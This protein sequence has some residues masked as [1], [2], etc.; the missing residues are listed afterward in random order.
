MRNIFD[1]YSQPENRITHALVTALNEDR[2][3]LNKF[4]HFILGSNKLN[5]KKLHVLEQSLPETP[6]PISEKDSMGLPDAWI[7]DNGGWCLLIESKVT[8][9]LKLSQLNRHVKTARKR[10]F[11]DIILLAIDSKPN[12]IKLPDKFI[13][14]EWSEIYVW[15]KGCIAFSEWALR[16]ASYFEIAEQK[17]ISDKK[18]Q[19]GALTVFSG[20]PFNSEN[21]YSY[22]EAKR[23]LVLAMEKLRN[24]KKLIKVLNIDSDREGRG[25]ITGKDQPAV[26][27]YIW[28]KNIPDDAN[29]TNYPHL[30]MAIKRD[31]VFAL[32]AIPNGIKKAF[33]KELLGGSQENF[34]SVFQA[35]FENF[36]NTSLLDSG[37]IP[38]VEILQR[39]YQTQR[40]APITDAKLEFDMRTFFNRGVKNSPVKIQK[41]WLNSVFETLNHKRANTQ[42]GVGAIFP[43]DKCKVAQGPELID[44]IAESWIACRPIIKKTIG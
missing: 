5:P 32:I 1:Q 3:L 13:F 28:F 36:I 6:E 42:L 9:P 30:T 8:A 16:T 19:E 22:S 37:V 33:L 26:W 17:M 18:F 21:P 4:L 29:F 2:K 25:A 14:K 24:H 20:I 27:D 12:K 31:H 11:E 15:L 7:H 34:N 41:A 23:V 44:R 35:I 39:H 38:W 10:G 43:Y 40:S